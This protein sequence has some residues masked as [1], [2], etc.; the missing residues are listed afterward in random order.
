VNGSL[1]FWLEQMS[2]FR[3]ALLYSLKLT[4]CLCVSR[5][6]GCKVHEWFFVSLASV[7]CLFAVAVSG[8]FGPMARLW[9]EEL[10]KDEE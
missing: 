2:I 5:F 4:G 8:N 6:L 10:I 1:L 9:T 3:V 7:P